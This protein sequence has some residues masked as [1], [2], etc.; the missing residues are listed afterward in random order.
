MK[1]CQQHCAHVTPLMLLWVNSLLRPLHT[2]RPTNKQP[3]PSFQLRYP[4]KQDIWRRSLYSML[5]CLTIYSVLCEAK[6]FNCSAYGI[7][8]TIIPYLLSYL[9]K[10]LLQAHSCNEL[11][12]M[13]GAC[14]DS[15]VG[16]G[17]T[18]FLFYLPRNKHD[19]LTTKGSISTACYCSC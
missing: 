18:Y 19:W 7:Y 14:V 17:H 16:F 2:Y 8:S 13:T 3:I 1:K 12:V 10:W 6:Q 5:K 11:W 4:A 9:L 15:A